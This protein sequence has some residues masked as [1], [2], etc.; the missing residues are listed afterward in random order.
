MTKQ[1][2]GLSWAGYRLVARGIAAATGVA[3][4][5]ALF[6][7]EA[8][9]A[10]FFAL[11]FTLTWVGSRLTQRM[12]T[13][14]QAFLALALFMNAAGSGWRLFERSL[15]DELCHLVTTA[16]VSVPFTLAVYR[17]VQEVLSA[18]P[19]LFAV[20][21]VSAGLSLNVGWEIYEFIVDRLTHVPPRM[22]LPDT[23]RDLVSDLAGALLAI[24]IGLRALREGAGVRS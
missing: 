11:Y 17:P 6:R 2:I 18:R 3:L 8:R 7:G 21:V 13:F 14:L 20:A 1:G 5:V 4:A 9:A 16:A 19:L 22:G 10:A 15:F 12:P 24:P 23:M